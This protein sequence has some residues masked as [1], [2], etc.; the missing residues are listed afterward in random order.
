MLESGG[1]AVGFGEFLWG[2][3]DERRVVF[4][5]DTRVW[6]FEKDLEAMHLPFDMGE[7]VAGVWQAVDFLYGEAVCV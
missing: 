7:D 6:G 2:G 3:P 5:H 1:D 4:G